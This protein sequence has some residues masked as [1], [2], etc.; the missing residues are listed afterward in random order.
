MNG[1]I[2]DIF[3]KGVLPLAVIGVLG[4][5]GKKFM[6]LR[7]PLKLRIL[8][9]LVVILF[10]LG[11]LFFF[12]TEVF[13]SYTTQFIPETSNIPGS[14]SRT[15]I[16][17]SFWQVT[18]DTPISLPILVKENRIISVSLSIDKAPVTVEYI[19]ERGAH[20]VILDTLE[21]TLFES[22]STEEL[23]GKN[24][25]LSGSI[26]KN[27]EKILVIKAKLDSDIKIYSY[28]VTRSYTSLFHWLL[29]IL[30]TLFWI[31]PAIFITKLLSKKIENKN[32]IL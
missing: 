6:N 27:D 31:I 26:S 12:Y 32:T 19:A 11:C 7:A 17:R 25:Y 2:Y 13:T 20:K 16:N 1:I 21:P 22:K 14:I 4:Y 23:K 24:A 9:F 10:I 8:S 30:I 3:I 28:T 15:D 29:I 5:A 18:K